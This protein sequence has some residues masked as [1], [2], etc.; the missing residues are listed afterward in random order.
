M[1]IG[2]RQ[3][4]KQ[5]TTNDQLKM[6]EDM[7]NKTISELVAESPDL[8]RQRWP[9]YLDQIKPDSPE[10]ETLWSRMCK[11][12]HIYDDD[13]QVIAFK[14]FILDPTKTELVYL[15]LKAA[16][17]SKMHL[18]CDK[19]GLVSASDGV[20]SDR[21]LVVTKPDVWLWDYTKPKDV[22]RGSS[23]NDWFGDNPF[24]GGRTDYQRR[25]CNECSMVCSRRE[26]LCSIYY[27]FLLCHECH[28]TKSDH[29]GEPYDAHKWEPL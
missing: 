21:R 20:A 12:A 16:R 13:A 26:L 5:L 18:L 9:E 24:G 29:N 8:V 10:F 25:Y 4:I 28:D 27:R 22:S 6:Q 11:R 15:G 14:Q 23:G 19:I 1:H 7:S 2:R 3:C 17:R